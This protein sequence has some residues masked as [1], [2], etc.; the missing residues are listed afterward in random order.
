VQ[1]RVFPSTQ[2]AACIQSAVLAA[3]HSKQCLHTH[4]MLLMGFGHQLQS[5]P[6]K[7]YNKLDKR[8]YFT[9]VSGS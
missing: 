4:D 6:N 3:L 2:L 1:R 9:Y 8:N 5:A 7:N